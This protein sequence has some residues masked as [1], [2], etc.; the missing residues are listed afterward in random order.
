MKND[1]SNCHMCDRVNNGKNTNQ[2]TQVKSECEHYYFINNV[3]INAKNCYISPK[4]NKKS[5]I[6]RN[7]NCFCVKHTLVSKKEL[8]TEYICN[9][10]QFDE[11]QCRNAFKMQFIEEL[12]LSK[13]VVSDD[14]NSIRSMK[15]NR[16][17]DETYNKSISE[18]SHKE[19]GSSSKHTISI[20]N[21]S[22][23]VSFNSKKRKKDKKKDKNE[24]EF[25]NSDRSS[26]IGSNRDSISQH[27]HFPRYFKIKY[28]LYQ[29][30]FKNEHTL[31]NLLKYLYHK[32][33]NN[34][35][36]CKDLSHMCVEGTN[37]IITKISNKLPW[38][39]N[40]EALEAYNNTSYESVMKSINKNFNFLFNTN[41]LDLSS[42]ISTYSREVDGFNWN[43]IIKN[44][45]FIMTNK[46]YFLF[47][48]K[49]PNKKNRKI[50]NINFF[51]LS[52]K[53]QRN[54]EIIP[55]KAKDDKEKENTKDTEFKEKD[56]DTDKKNSLSKTKKNLK[57]VSKMTSSKVINVNYSEVLNIFER[58]RSKIC[59]IFTNKMNDKITIAEE[60]LINL[61]NFEVEE[62]N[63][64]I[65]FSTPPF[66][67]EI[68]KL[69]IETKSV[70][71]KK[72]VKVLSSNDKTYIILHLKEDK[73]FAVVNEI[74]C[75][76]LDFDDTD[77]SNLEKVY[78]PVKSVKYMED[79][80]I[81]RIIYDPAITDLLPKSK[82]KSYQENPYYLNV[83]LLV[84]FVDKFEIIRLPDFRLECKMDTLDMIFK[85]LK[86]NKLRASNLDFQPKNNKYKDNISDCFHA[87]DRYQLYHY[88]IDLVRD[89]D[90]VNAV[91]INVKSIFIQDEIINIVPTVSTYGEFLII[92]NSKSLLEFFDTETFTKFFV[93]NPNMEVLHFSKISIK[94]LEDNKVE[95]LENS[96]E[97]DEMS[98]CVYETCLVLIGSKYEFNILPIGFLDDFYV[99]YSK[100]SYNEK[101]EKPQ[102]AQNSQCTSNKDINNVI[103]NE[104]L[105]KI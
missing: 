24:E 58:D 2:N 71:L 61:D 46:N 18:S 27:V 31:N 35:S 79:I 19:L 44:N 97:I 94:L 62:T 96:E 48:I 74:C 81:V 72:V 39:K 16:D 49:S 55:I 101:N 12:V 38:H 91:I 1:C 50:T 102:N 83:S 100:H 9:Q 25:I 10:C 64:I 28:N 68:N 21:E 41:H 87:V 56:E 53:F 33:K 13:N 30:L 37:K 92:L 17:D 85:V 47:V 26:N 93:F 52:F 105:K 40:L 3:E 5:L 20:T 77:S 90:F 22:S 98:L 95:N 75:F 78:K 70:G 57:L 45:F 54:I 80:N 67:N 65:K 32:N 51:Y 4:G 60:E 69:E 82:I 88:Q 104:K 99:D 34:E 36:F 86:V 63:K 11:C 8:E 7:M 23:T 103:L 73:G 43:D 15:V 66:M 42:Y 76:R 14:A 29:M 59:S 89:Y 6:V 84:S